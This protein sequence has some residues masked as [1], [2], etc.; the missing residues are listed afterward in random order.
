[1]T[2]RCEVHT[3]EPEFVRFGCDGIMVMENN[4]LSRRSFLLAGLSGP[5]ISCASGFTFSYTTRGRV[6]FI[7]NIVQPAEAPDVGVEV[8]MG[9]ARPVM[10]APMG[11][12]EW[13]VFGEPCIWRLRDSR[14]ICAVAIGEDEMPSVGDYHYLWYISEDEGTNW[15]QFAIH[16]SEAKGFIRERFTCSDGS[17]MHYELE[18]VSVEELTNTKPRPFQ[19][20][21]PALVQ[22]LSV[23]YRLGDLPKELRSIAWYT[24]EPHDTVWRVSRATMDQDILIPVFKEAVVDNQDCD[25]L[26]SSYVATRF[27]RLVRYI[28]DARLSAPVVHKHYDSKWARPHDFGIPLGTNTVLRIQLPTPSGAPLHNQTLEPI[29]EVPS[30]QLI[31]APKRGRLRLSRL[32][33]GAD[34]GLYPNIFSSNDAG[35][36][37]SYYASVPFSRVGPFAIVRAHVTPGMPAGNWLALIRTVGQSTT[38]CPLLLTC[39]YDRGRSWKPPVAIRPSSVNPVGGLLRNGIAFRMYGRPGQFIMFCADGEGRKWGNDIMLVP[40]VRNSRGTGYIP[41]SCCNSSIQVIGP[42]RFVVAY[43]DYSFRDRSNNVRKAVLVRQIA[44]WPR[45][46][47]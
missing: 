20:E 26:A 29:L 42:D 45:T 1:M 40:A 19:G 43:T 5:S 9:P 4:R 6:E 44:A 30:G 31:V 21:N 47:T 23:L 13:G 34:T 14:L 41:N 12:R 36:T 11:D 33:N 8:E 3:G 46:T 35:R 39:S 22:G 24:R 27:A 32:E 18:I 16:D 25:L 38:S 2:R 7:D 28:G 37:W 17:Q 15:T 10:M